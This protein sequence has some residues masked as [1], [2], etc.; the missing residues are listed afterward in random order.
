[1]LEISSVFRHVDLNIKNDLNI[2]DYEFEYTVD[3]I[4]I[5]KKNS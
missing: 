3:E 1:M 4:K 2:N 5:I